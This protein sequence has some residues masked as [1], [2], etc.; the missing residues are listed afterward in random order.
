M[1]TN[2]YVYTKATQYNKEL[3]QHRDFGVTDAK[4]RKVGAALIV[5]HHTYE[6]DFDPKRYCGT[7]VQEAD[8]G[9]WWTYAVQSTRNG[10]KF[11]A[12]AKTMKFRTKGERDV[13][14]A[15]ALARAVK[16][17]VR[18]HTKAAPAP[19]ETKPN[20]FATLRD[21]N[22]AKRAEKGTVIVCGVEQPA[23]RDENGAIYT[24]P[25]HTTVPAKA[26][27]DGYHLFMIF[28]HVTNKRLPMVYN[29]RHT[30]EEASLFNYSESRR[31]ERYFSYYHPF[32]PYQPLRRQNYFASL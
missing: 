18:K 30:A 7:V 29:F 28:D 8:L 31:I 3:G 16:A 10:T 6:Q 5:G 2:G 14:A 12:S 21:E 17:G 11:G 19:V 26:G 9:L 27:L 20:P 13:A 24:A 25:V 23:T 4:G 15:K 1:N 32:G 22:R